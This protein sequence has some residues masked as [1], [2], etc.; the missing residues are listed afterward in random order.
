MLIFHDI[1]L[2]GTTYATLSCPFQGPVLLSSLTD[3]TKYWL[4]GGEVGKWSLQLCPLH[5]G[6]GGDEGL[7]EDQEEDGNNPNLPL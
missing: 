1:F 3:G 2:Y 6:N 5:L 7:R 4:P